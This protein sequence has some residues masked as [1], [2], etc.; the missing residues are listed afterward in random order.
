VEDGGDSG[1]VTLT[2][3]DEPTEEGTALNAETLNRFMTKDFALKD[4]NGDGVVNSSDVTEFRSRIM[5]GTTTA[6]DDYNGDGTV[7]AQDVA[8]YEKQVNRF[9]DVKQ[10]MAAL[11]GQYMTPQGLL[12]QWGTVTI[13]P[14][15][16]DTPTSAIVNFPLAYSATPLVFTQEVTSVPHNVAVGTMRNAVDP[17]KQVEIVL[18]RADTVST[19]INWFA[20]GKGA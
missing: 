14:S 19:V 8:E 2:R 7:D 3:A 1:Y 6:E 5:A 16:A 4:Y 15:A 18:A 17:L 13:T 10:Q 9:G 20:I 11:N 12:L